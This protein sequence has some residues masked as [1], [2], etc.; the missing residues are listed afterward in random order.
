[1]DTNDSQRNRQLPD[2]EG[3]IQPLKRVRV[4][5]TQISNPMITSNR[6]DIITGE[7]SVAGTSGV[8]KSSPPKIRKMPPIVA[9]MQ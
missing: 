1:M 8:V 4:Y 9:K 3:F 5:K 6:Y 7:T 2:E